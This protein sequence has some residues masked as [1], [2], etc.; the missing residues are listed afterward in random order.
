MAARQAG[1]AA[2]PV[3]AQQLADAFVH[4]AQANHYMVGVVPGYTD[5]ELDAAEQILIARENSCPTLRH[6]TSALDIIEQRRRE[7]RRLTFSHGTAG[8]HAYEHTAPCT[9]MRVRTCLELHPGDPDHWCGPCR[10]VAAQRG[11]VRS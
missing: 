11:K 5:D 2:D 4:V 10:D 1:Q 8:R 3:R 7:M 6:V 9:Y